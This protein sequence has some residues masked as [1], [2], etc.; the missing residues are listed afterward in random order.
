MTNLLT[1]GNPKIEKGMKMGYLTHILHLAP[2]DLSGYQVCSMADG[3][4]VPCLNLAGRGGM[5]R[6]GENT[7][8]IQKARIR[9]TRQFFENREVFM[10]RI[11]KEIQNSIRYAQKHNLIP[12]IRLNG[13]SDLPW[14]KFRVTLNG[15][16]Y[17]NVMDA[18]P[19]IQFYDYTKIYGRKVPKNYH[20]TF[21]R[22]AHNELNVIKA[23]QSNMSIAVVFDN[24]KPM[25]ETFMG[26]MVIN[27]DDTDLRF[28]DDNNV[29]VGLKAKGPAKKDASGFVV[30]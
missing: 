30:R 3:C 13:T 22:S 19:D 27:G 7:N 23:I 28:L 14:E 9:K 10:A 17:R 15:V 5:F 11:V 4:Q 25:P 24:K 29:I 26:K 20:L 1:R 8:I 16:E 18:F 12:V 2:F 21:S 6:K